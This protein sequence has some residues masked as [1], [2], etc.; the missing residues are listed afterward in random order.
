VQVNYLGYPGTLGAPFVD[1][2]VVDEFIVPPDQQPFF[3]EELVHLPGC[4]QVNDSQRPIDPRTPTRAECGLPEEGVV[5]AAF[6]NTYKITPE[7]F[8]V[9]MAL[10]RGQ[11]GSVIWLL[12]ANPHV[13][14]NLRR[15][16]AARGVGPRRLV[17]APRQPLAEHLARHRVADLFLDTF[18]YNGHTTASDALWA[19]L[20]VLTLAGETFVS[21]VAGSLLRAVGLPELVTT[22]PEEYRELAGSLARDPRRLAELRARLEANRG[23]SPLFD[24]GR[25]AVGL[26][27]AFATM[28]ARHAAGRPPEAFAVEPAE[29]ASRRR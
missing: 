11:P 13:A 19:G 4:Y 10:L 9:W 25:F 5:F 28:W 24:A 14:D 18:P 8:D 20:P 2:I 15:E 26:E 21:R 1:Y 3:D 16:A 27:R 29:A 12:E 6:N 22:T 7:M 17:F 23:T